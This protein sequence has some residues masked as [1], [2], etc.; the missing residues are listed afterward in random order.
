[1]VGFFDCVIVYEVG[2]WFGWVLCIVEWLIDCEVCLVGWWVF[3][4]YDVYWN[5]VFDYVCE[6]LVD[7]FWLYGLII[8]YGMEWL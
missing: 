3:E 6:M 8:G 1:L 5:L 7:L 4:Y 2:V